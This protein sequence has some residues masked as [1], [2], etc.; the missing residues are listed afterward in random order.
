[1]ASGWQTPRVPS[2]FVV[3]KSETRRERVTIAAGS[4]G[5]PEAVNGLGADVTEFWYMDE[6]GGYYS[7]QNIPAGGRVTLNPV[8]KPRDTEKSKALRIWYSREWHNITGRLKVTGPEFLTPRTYLAFMDAVPFLD[9]SASKGA[10]PR[11]KSV[12]FGILKEGNDGG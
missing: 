12:I 4:S 9:E 1:L 11:V 3:R 7:A 6:K 8:S 5:K 2:H 10:E